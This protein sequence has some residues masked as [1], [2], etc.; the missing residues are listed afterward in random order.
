MGLVGVGWEGGGWEVE[1]WRAEGVVR[2][3]GDGWS[4][5]VVVDGCRRWVWG[6]GEEVMDM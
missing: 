6:W 2:W 1:A 5:G 4:C 3:R